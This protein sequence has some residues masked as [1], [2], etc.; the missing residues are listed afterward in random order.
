M[1]QLFGI[2]L[3][4]L[5][6]ISQRKPPTSN[7]AKQTRVKYARVVDGKA[8]CGRGSTI[9]GVTR[10]CRVRAVEFH[11]LHVGAITGSGR[12]IVAGGSPSGHVSCWPR[13]LA[14]A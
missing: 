14:L 2:A 9:G 8:L 11:P 10:T 4:T 5:G 6:A 1:K 12:A 13:S 3:V 7:L